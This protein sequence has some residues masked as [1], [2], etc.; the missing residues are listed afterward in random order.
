MKKA[1]LTET[2]NYGPQNLVLIELSFDSKNSKQT[3]QGENT[4]TLAGQETSKKANVTRTQWTREE[5]S[6]CL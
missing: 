4:P 3:F 6:K 5:N 2:I 1:V